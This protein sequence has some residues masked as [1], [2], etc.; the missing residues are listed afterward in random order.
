MST[1][2][3]TLT[4]SKKQSLGRRNTLKSSWSVSEV[5]SKRATRLDDAKPTG[6]PTEADGRFLS[7]RHLRGRITRDRQSRDGLTF[8][9]DVPEHSPG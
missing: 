6:S 1:R 9:S 7:G 5:T 2:T 4:L 8:S 3:L